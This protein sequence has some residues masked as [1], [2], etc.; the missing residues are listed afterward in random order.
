MKRVYRSTASAGILLVCPIDTSLQHILRIPL[1]ARVLKPVTELTSARNG[2][3]L[4]GNEVAKLKEP[5]P[6]KSERAL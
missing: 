6:T 2:I 3:R 4:G 5:L 1:L